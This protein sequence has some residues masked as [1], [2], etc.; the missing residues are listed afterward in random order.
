VSVAGFFVKPAFPFV[1]RS[2]NFV[3]NQPVQLVMGQFT[4]YKV[5]LL[6]LLIPLLVCLVLGLV[7][8]QPDQPWS[9]ILNWGLYGLLGFL[10]HRLSWLIHHQIRGI[11]FEKS[12][13]SQ[14]PYLITGIGFTYGLVLLFNDLETV[15]KMA[16]LIALQVAAVS[17]LVHLLMVS[18]G[19]LQK[20]ALLTQAKALAKISIELQVEGRPVQVPLECLLAV[21]VEDHYCQIWYEAQNA[22]Q[23]VMTHGSLKNLAARA[24]GHLVQISRSALVNPSKVLQAEVGKETQVWLPGIAQPFKVSRSYRKQAQKWA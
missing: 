2:G 23:R 18:T 24:E 22:V 15:Q 13:A 11:R 4:R 6:S 10:G 20:I 7:Q 9:P 21:Q 1:L 8:T 12:F 17:A 16:G 3:N 19:T 14:A 5:D